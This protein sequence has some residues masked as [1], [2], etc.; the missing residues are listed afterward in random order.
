MLNFLKHNIYGRIICK[1]AYESDMHWTWYPMYALITG[2]FLYVVFG[3]IYDVW[4][5]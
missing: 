4:T 2:C 1:D 3:T 5:M